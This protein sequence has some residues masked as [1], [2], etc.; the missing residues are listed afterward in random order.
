M[1]LVVVPNALDARPGSGE[2]DLADWLPLGTVRRAAG[3]RHWV[4]ENARSARA[5]LKGVGAIV[6]LAAPLQAIAI[7]EWPRQGGAE[8]DVSLLLRPALD[9]HALGLLSDSGL[10][11]LADPGAALVAAAHARGVP[12]E[13]LP[14]PSAIA[15]AVAASGLDGQRFAFVGYVPAD[16]A[17]RDARLRDLE[18]ASARDRATQ[19]CIETPYRNRALLEALLRVL[20]PAT[21]VSVAV[22]VGTAH[23][24][25]RTDTIEGW[26]RRPADLPTDVPAV[27][28]WLAAP[29]G[30]DVSPA[31]GPERPRTA[32]PSRD[33]RPARPAS[34]RRARRPSSST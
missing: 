25:V 14:G 5:F 4:V 2:T 7:A 3:I 26:R 34:R 18:A 31:R 30:A 17:A 11:G 13:V 24:S 32:M 8:D 1:T 15:L 20:R 33:R 27:F 6:P 12:V 22:G 29:G 23:A 10:P 16:A 9:G 19:L 28:A 21:R